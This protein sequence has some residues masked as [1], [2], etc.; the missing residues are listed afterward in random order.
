MVSH[1]AFS[2]AYAEL[3]RLDDVR[4]LA[5]QQREL[6]YDAL[7]CIYAKKQQDLVRKSISQHRNNAKRY[8]ERY[9]NGESI[10]AIAEAIEPPSGLPPT[11]LARVLLEEILSL[12]RGKEVNAYLKE[13][14][15]LNE[16]RLQRE[17]QRA[18]EA[19]ACCASSRIE[20]G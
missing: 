10:V 5:E 15:R 19:D 4:R 9:Q 17:V 16:P 18:V 13:P 14:H 6:S 3:H 1:R 2:D 12:N 20:R 8:V 7:L 11:M